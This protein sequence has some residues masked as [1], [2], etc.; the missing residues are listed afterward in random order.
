MSRIRTIRLNPDLPDQTHQVILPDGVFIVRLRWNVRMTSWFLSLRNNRR[1]PLVLGVR[2]ALD[3]DILAQYA[4]VDGM[5]RGVLMA[6][7]LEAGQERPPVNA[8][9]RHELGRTV[10][11]LYVDPPDAS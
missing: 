9:G 10:R 5:P 8:I 3:T 6:V 2:L 11:L 7:S 4:H 1:E